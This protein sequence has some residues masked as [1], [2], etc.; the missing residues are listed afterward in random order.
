MD[1]KIKKSRAT[2]KGKFTRKCTL[3]E[4]TLDALEPYEVNKLIYDEVTLAFEKVEEQNENLMEYYETLQDQGVLNVVKEAEEYIKVLDRKKHDL[5]SRVV[6][7]KTEINAI[8]VKS[9]PSPT[10]SG[11]IR[12]YG[13]FIKDYERIMVPRY[14]ND[15]YALYQCLI[16]EAKLCVTG[17]ED[18]YNEMVSRL[19]NEY[20][21]PC[22][23][24]DSIVND[25]KSL[26]PVPEG[27]YDKLIKT[28]DVIERA[29]LDM[30]KLG[31]KSEMDT[32]SIVS[33]VERI[34]PRKL[35]HDWVVKASEADKD[36]ERSL[37]EKLLNFLLQEKRICKYLD[38][39]IRSNTSKKVNACS[40]DNEP[41]NIAIALND[42]KLSQV[43]SNNMV[44]DC[45]TNV[46]KLLSSMSNNK[47]EN[48]N[49]AKHKKYCFYHNL[50]GH[51]ITECFNFIRLTSFD[52][53]SVLRNFNVCFRCLIPGHVS[54]YWKHIKLS[55]NV[56]INGTKCGLDHHEFLHDLLYKK[57]SGNL[58]SRK[59][60]ILGV[61]IVKSVSTNLTTLWDGGSTASLI[62]HKKA[63]EMNLK[64]SNV[65]LSITKVGN[66]VEIIESKEYLVP[67]IDMNGKTYQITCCGMEE[68][69]APLE[70]VDISIASKLFPCI[71]TMAIH[72]PFGEIHML[73]GL[74]NTMLL[75]QVIDSVDNLQL[76]K[77]RYGYVLRGSHPAIIAN[78]SPMNTHVSIYHVNIKTVN[79]I[80][81]ASCK[82]V[83]DDIEHYFG[84][85]NLG[86]SCVPK[87]GSCRCGK[88][89][90]GN[91]DYSLKEERELKLI[92]EGLSYDKT[93][94]KWS[95]RYPWIKDPFN[96]PN[97]YPL[98][99]ACLV[100]TE[101]RLKKS[102]SVYWEAYK[103]EMQS[104]GDINHIVSKG[105]F[106]IKH[107]LM[108]KDHPANSRIDLIKVD[109][110][111][112]LGVKWAPHEDFF[113]FS[114]K[115][116]FSDKYRKVNKG[117]NLTA[118]NILENMPDVLTKRIVFS[119]MVS[120]Y[121]PY[122][123]INPLMLKGKIKWKFTASNAQFQNGIS[124]ALIK[125]VKK[126]LLVVI[127]DSI[128]TFSKLQVTLFK[129]SNI[130]NQRPI[131]IKPASNIELG[132]YLCPNDLL[133]GRST[134]Q[135]PSGSA[136]KN[137]SFQEIIV[138]KDHIVSAFW[139]K[140][141]DLWGSVSLKND[142][143]LNF[144]N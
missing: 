33:L 49:I 100:S 35:Q 128:L 107:F 127:G 5:W 64:G 87:C 131:G 119:V 86:I 112:V 134:G 63:R 54:N 84:I 50:H 26:E 74:D 41:S 22:K 117:P 12:S 92:T 19:R 133:L 85:E 66:V 95:Y 111:K 52:K 44:V 56:K 114:V 130:W 21:D 144:F 73:I 53:K 55:C 51:D 7:S 104:M 68:I 40:V 97:N 82:S 20:G 14:G 72:R 89:A 6:K 60:Y 24:T 10:F 77:N 36:D 109:E 90:P 61:S 121:D 129:I 46:T 28:V 4:E 9:L 138:F 15:P 143:L 32:I 37:F 99:K 136:N 96:L 62:T 141:R 43:S 3:L 17:V 140:D 18:N 59:G 125:S 81:I 31:L 1:T 39:N 124:E 98:A 115:I 88:C 16:G 108:S 71:E 42:L 78:D 25:L 48:D 11:D 69:S 23:I 122:G 113:S 76:L 79:E 30:E 70:F 103:N 91:Q 13:I 101:K 45:L 38:R 132:K 126:Y 118:S 102:G 2:A 47:Q 110:D 34:L 57:V 83:K 80:N 116:N 135:A 29:W 67:L 106:K 75:P 8:K 123:F 105:G 142:S 139:K 93:N 94:L 58:M 27:N 120:Q 137:P 65:T